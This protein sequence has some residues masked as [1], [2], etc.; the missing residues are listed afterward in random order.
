MREELPEMNLYGQTR[1]MTVPQS[2]EQPA[3]TRN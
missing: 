1:A 2:E 3:E